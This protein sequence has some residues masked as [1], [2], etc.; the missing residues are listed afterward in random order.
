[1]S[2]TWCRCTVKSIDGDSIRVVTSDDRQLSV[3]LRGADSYL[4]ALLRDGMRLNILNPSIP[5]L[6]V[7]EPDFLMD[8]S[9]L[10]AL[11]TEYG[12]HPLLYTVGRL[13]PRANSQAILLGNFAGSAL[14]DIINQPDFSFARTLS[15]SFREQALQFC[16][17]PDFSPLLF[18]T[19]AQQQ[20]RNLQ[21]V[22]ERLFS[23]DDGMSGYDR[24]KAIL[25]PSFVCERLGLQGRVDLMTTDMRLL[26]EQKSGKNYKIEKYLRGQKDSS[27]L[28]KDDHYVQL[29][30]Y[31]GVLRYN[32]G[33]G[34][35]QTDMHLLYSRYPAA[36]GLLA[37]DFHRKLFHEAIELRNRV[38]AQEFATAREGFGSLLPKLNT[39]TVYEGIERSDFFN[40]YIASRTEQLSRQLDSLDAKEREYLERQMTFV[41]REQLY[42]KLG[43]TQEQGRAAADLWNMS[44]AE[45]REA[46]NI[47][48][49]LCITAKEQSAEG[50]GYDLLTLETADGPCTT[51]SAL[52]FYPNFRRGDMVYLYAYN[53]VPDVRKSLLFR[54]RMMDITANRV[55]IKLNDGQQNVQVF[56]TPS[57]IT[58]Q[59]SPVSPKYA[60]EHDTSDVNTSSAIRSLMAFATSSKWKRQLLLGQRE[61]KAD[62]SV[63]LTRSY[64]PHYDDIVL[65]QKQALDY[66]LLIGPPGTGKTSMALRFIVEEELS[67]TYHSITHQRPST[68]PSILLMAYTNRAVDEICYMLVD[69]GI[70]FLRLG[71]EASCDPRF[72]SHLLEAVLDGKPKLDDV[73]RHIIQTR[74]VVST[75]ATMQSRPFIFQLKH[76]SLCVVDEASQILEPNIIGLLA[77][78]A[79]GRF[80]LVGDYK[81][82]P[83]VV[84]QP[85]DAFE[86]L[87]ERLIRWERQ[88]HRQQFIGV[89]HRQG[90][91]H[92]DVAAFANELFY[93]SENLQPVPC[94]HQLDTSLHYDEPSQD[95]LDDLLK[96]RRV[97]F[98]DCGPIVPAD[99]DKINIAEA[100]IVAD[101]LRRIYRQC[102]TSDFDTTKTVGVIVPYR[103]QI[104]MIR[105]EIER[106]GIPDLMQIS[107]DTVERYQGSQRDVIIYSFTVQHDYQL[108]FLTANC[109]VEDGM[110]IDRK[111]NVALTRARKQLLITGCAAVLQ[112]NP[113]FAEL[114]KRYVVSY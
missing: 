65:R 50:S 24:S 55:L 16:T 95:C 99:C 7:V 80:V 73:R 84:Q 33:I 100:R 27:F 45:K 96:E 28:Q 22:V 76:F 92:P 15:E 88:Q 19:D 17:C 11:F 38:V 46:G 85:G 34:D 77:S 3:P 105:H 58:N 75:T 26:V 49:D 89:L 111:L 97:L 108:D 69:A 25:E 93:I 60:I 113:L 110:I 83:A 13:L 72:K 36:D 37:V 102:G 48:T 106:L 21:E 79:V 70:D 57:P 52:D 82:L 29:L 59:Q 51:S 41:Y 63:T 14:D 23:L 98:M 91:M 5:E 64:H 1:M 103:N 43:S 8:I 114:I 66:F 35:S 47:M 4:F 74:V 6:I 90:R 10:A 42:S 30:L 40:R 109:I 86:S 32:F 78:D 68:T 81:Q 53:D 112:H 31:Y 87:F 67:N 20:V 39:E 104:A 61:P 71:N 54:G 9:A 107:I 94:P 2:D 101:L 56:D 62:T 12:H 44:L 18:K